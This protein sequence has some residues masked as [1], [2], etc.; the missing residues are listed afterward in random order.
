MSHRYTSEGCDFQW[1]SQPFL[2][3][4]FSTESHKRDYIVYNKLR[5]RFT[6][7]ITKFIINTNTDDS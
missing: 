2:L 3:P 6:K 4:N 7:T 1:K 5:Y